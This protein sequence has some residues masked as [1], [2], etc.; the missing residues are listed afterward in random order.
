MDLSFERQSELNAAWSASADGK[1][2]RELQESLHEI[3][4]SKHVDE[5]KKSIAGVKDS[6][7]RRSLDSGTREANEQHLKLLEMRLSDAEFTR[8]FA[9]LTDDSKASA[10]A[11]HRAKQ[12]QMQA[13]IEKSAAV[14]KLSNE[15]SEKF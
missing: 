2:M 11:V 3:M 7:M 5:L 1:R 9:R 14:R 10:I 8:T 4:E 6:L 13:E 15:M 12:E